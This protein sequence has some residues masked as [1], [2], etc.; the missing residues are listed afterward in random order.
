MKKILLI[1]SNSFV[2]RNLVKFLLSDPELFVYG[3]SRKNDENLNLG[4]NY[5]HILRDLKAGNWTEGLPSGIDVV[6]YLVQS[7]NYRDFPSQVEDIFTINVK[8]LI[9]TL[10]WARKN[11]VKQFINL[12]SASVYGNAP[13][14]YK[15]R[16]E[17][18][19]AINSFYAATKFSSEI[20]V[21]QFSGYFNT[22][23][24]RISTVFGKGQRGML[25][26]NLISNVIEGKTISINGRQGFE[27]NP[28][29][30]SDLVRYLSNFIYFKSKNDLYNL[31]GDSVYTLHEFVNLIGN[32]LGINPKIKYIDNLEY[33]ICS[34]TSR[35]NSE[36]N[37]YN[38][39]S[40]ID[41]IDKIIT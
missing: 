40:V 15:F 6:Y 17:N 23:N 27:F 11:S 29:F 20:F 22:L 30:V 16:E 5:F 13:I 24:L 10:D 2:G 18:E 8:S 39:I 9:E 21:N 34:D 41:A 31:G 25:I 33:S 37:M 32:R 4:I 26:P 3:V 12:S 38:Q 28:I 35:F 14:G 7:A 19:V 1:G 36:F